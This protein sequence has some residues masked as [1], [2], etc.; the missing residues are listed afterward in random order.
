M[1]GPPTPASTP[2]A[3]APTPASTWALRPE[4][5]SEVAGISRA[6][7]TPTITNSPPSRETTEVFN[8]VPTQRASG[9]E[10]TAGIAIQ[11]TLDHSI[12]R[13]IEGTINNE[14]MVASTIV[15]IMPW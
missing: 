4:I 5:G 10:I 3:P 8:E 14:A 9:V 6:A 7:P 13:H 15:I 12:S 1:A 2:P 11:P